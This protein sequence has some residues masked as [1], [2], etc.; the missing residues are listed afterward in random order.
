VEEHA[1]QSEVTKEF[2]RFAHSYDSYNEI[3]KRV[4]KT[5][6]ENITTHKYKT[7]ID[8]GCGSGGVYKNLQIQEKLVDQFIALDAS[9]NMLAIHPNDKNV[10]KIC[11]DFDSY[12]AFLNIKKE[13][14]TLLL[15]ASSLQW[16]KDLD[17]LFLRLSRLSTDAYFA[18]FTANTFKTL[19]QTAAISSPIYSMGILQKYIERYYDASYKLKTYQLQFE[20]VK[21]MFR[22]IKKS[23]VSG[24]EKQLSY[25]EIKSVMESY[26]LDYLEFEVLFVKATS[27]KSK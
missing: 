10:E 5:L 19:H 22:Y 20:S 4:A 24:G 2:S 23:G 15:S 12:K 27:L 8:I 6:V 26:P 18:I 3:Q 14:D 7:I 16:T 17:T 13:E 21:K 9:K 11:E 25:K 1:Q